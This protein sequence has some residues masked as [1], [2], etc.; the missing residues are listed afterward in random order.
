MLVIFYFGAFELLNLI[1]SSLF[2]CLVSFYPDR[3]N[4]RPRLGSW[5]I[6]GVPVGRAACQV[7]LSGGTGFSAHYEPSENINVKKAG[8][9]QPGLEI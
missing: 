3:S 4:W 8:Q 1:V 5:A 9:D 6:G 7:L 2:S